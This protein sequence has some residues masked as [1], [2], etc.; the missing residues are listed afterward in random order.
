MV[1]L[2]WNGLAL[3]SFYGLVGIGLAIIRGLWGV[4]NLSQGEFMLLGGYIC[5]LLVSAFGFNIILAIIISLIIIGAGLALIARGTFHFTKNDLVNGFILSTG[6][7]LIIQ[8]VLELTVG[9]R[10]REVSVS[11][12]GGI[13]F[14]GANISYLRLIV[15]AC[16]IVLVF[17]TSWFLNKTKQG[18]YIRAAALNTKAAKLVG[19]NVNNVELLSY[20]ISGILAAFAG[21]GMVIQFVVTPYLGS[22]YVLK[23]VAAMLLAGAYKGVGN[24]KATYVCGLLL[25]MVE[26]IGASLTASKWQDLFAYFLLYFGLILASRLTNKQQGGK[27]NVISK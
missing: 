2:I 12:L 24:I 26:S 22:R 21:L 5:F 14:L 19:I 1:Q 18:R 16:T 15:F 11:I 6:L 13:E 27:S 8:N 4:L 3:G 7:S 10:P 9:S 25:G 17:F 20:M 23:G